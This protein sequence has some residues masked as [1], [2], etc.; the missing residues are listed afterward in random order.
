MNESGL[1]IIPAID[2]KGGK[3]VRLLQGRDNQTTEYSPDPVA[4][5]EEW[6]RQGAKRLHVVNLDGAFGRASRNGEIVCEISRRVDAL[7]EFGGG[8]RTWEDIVAAIQAGVGKVVLGTVAIEH[9]EILRKIIDTY[10]AGRLI[11]ALDAVDGKVATRGWQHITG[12]E[13]EAFAREMKA[14]GVEEILATD[15]KRDGMLVG[16]DIR[17]LRLLA[18][19]GI[20]VIASGGISSDD[21]VRALVSLNEPR[22]TG[23]IVG[24]ALY[25]KKVTFASLVAAASSAPRSNSGT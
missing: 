1:E 16:P 19:T 13:V 3:C 12:H 15:V 11:V 7:V 5:A 10:G 24:K 17:G 18:E 9:P 4:V 20:S 22:I 8:L 21:D 6:V 25:E 14:T 23:V 2:L